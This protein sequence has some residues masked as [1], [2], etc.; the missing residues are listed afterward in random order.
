MNGAGS[1]SIQGTPSSS[2]YLDGHI[3]RNERS[4]KLHENL[5][6][7]LRLRDIWMLVDPPLLGGRVKFF[8]LEYNGGFKKGDK[9]LE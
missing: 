5:D 4:H 8:K 7:L 3:I 6:S 9:S 1:S 2:M